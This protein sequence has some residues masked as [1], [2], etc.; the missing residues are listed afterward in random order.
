MER[1]KFVI[2][3]GSLAA[4]SAAAT[5]T[6]AFTAMTASR[7]STIDVENDS[8]G[9]LRL[10][11]T[12]ESDLVS[13]DGDGELSINI[14]GVNVNSTYQIGSS[15]KKGDKI[16][17]TLG[18]QPS[19]NSP[20]GNAAFVITNT[21]SEPKEVTLSYELG[22][23]AELNSDGSELFIDTRARPGDSWEGGDGGPSM[24]IDS[25][26][27][28]DSISF[29]GGYNGPLRSGGGFG[30]SLI[31]DTTGEN[32]GESESMSGTFT[33]TAEEVEE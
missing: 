12:H 7:S 26:N 27:E 16:Y 32:A 28:S 30:V 4:G 1:R 18:D 13:E 3:L 8:D 25:D 2:G 11:A 6:G 14:D 10:E 31:I 15:F 19:S 23:E 22:S 5:G 33:I 21:D 17:D 24:T 29:P 20:T 9:L